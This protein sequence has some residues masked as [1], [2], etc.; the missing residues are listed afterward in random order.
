MKVLLFTSP[1][2]Y[3]ADN[4]IPLAKYLKTKGVD[5]DASY[6]LSP[7]DS[8]LEFDMLSNQKSLVSTNF[9][10]NEKKYD[11]IILTQPWWYQ[12]V[13]IVDLSKRLKI[14]FVIVDH[15]P[16]MIRYTRRDGAMSHLYRKDLRGAHTFFA[17]GIETVNIMRKLGSKVNMQVVGSS[18]IDE[19][20]NLAKVEKNNAGY[21]VFDT[22]NKMEDKSTVKKFLD[23]LK[24]NKNDTFIIREHSRSPKYFRKACSFL[25]V[26]IRNDLSEFE[27]YNYSNFIYS[28]PSSAMIVPALLK[29]KIFTLY[30]EHE[31][32]EARRYNIKY[33]NIFPDLNASI[34]QKEEF[35]Y[36]TFLAN[37]ILYREDQST[38]ERIYKYLIKYFG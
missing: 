24:N 5:V 17:Y 36:N 22:S 14:P 6:Q 11:V 9:L 25:N 16:P 37:N 2:Q 28:F 32:L 20:V 10:K 35:N 18:R 3:Y 7:D 29:K 4:L 13:N 12:E 1:Y 26:S 21:V 34:N 8:N 27:L 33:S 23:F 31:C 38:N 19:M 15:A 30:K